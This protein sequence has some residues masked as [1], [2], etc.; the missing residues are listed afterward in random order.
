MIH[1]PDDN[2]GHAAVFVLSRLRDA[3]HSSF[4]AGG[5]VRD[6][7]LGL[8]PKD[9]DV[10]TEAVPTRVVELFPRARTVGAQFGVVLV[11]RHGVDIEVATFRSDGT[12][13]DGRRPDSVR[14]GTAEEDAQRRDFTI[15]GL[16]FDPFENRV[17]D[18]VN[19]QADLKDG[20]IRTIGDPSLRF[21]ED[22]LRMLRAVRFAARFDFQIAAETMT[23][24]Q[25]NAAKLSLVSVERIWMELERMLVHESR[26][27]AWRHIVESG[28]RSHLAPGWP[29]SEGVD[30]FARKR[31]EGFPLG[32][33]NVAAAF[34]ALVS[35]L[36]AKSVADVC[37]GLRLSNQLTRDVRWLVA[38]LPSVHRPKAIELADL[39]ILI[40]DRCWPALLDLLRADLSAKGEG[41]EIIS[42]LQGRADSIPEE[43]VAP[44]PL[45]T[46]DD[47][48][49]LGYSPHRC[50]GPILKAVYRA[51]LNEELDSRDAAIAMAKRLLNESGVG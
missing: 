7:L 35:D 27:Q 50:F 37:R 44:P 36:S 16:F 43:R 21:G 14:F 17:I 12:Y 41:L 32:F 33:S 49:S 5:C 51:Q 34:A 30:T 29:V 22:H 24:I 18:F 47:L 2:A 19:G 15:N 6:R 23:A 40:A 10:A 9:Y 31:L 45:V 20:I 1:L 26:A 38:S 4:L 42:D 8:E 25:D 46:G 28:L 13:S 48:Q 39:K 3:G 11:R